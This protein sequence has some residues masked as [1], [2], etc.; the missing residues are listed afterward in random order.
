VRPDGSGLRQLTSGENQDVGPSW[1]RSRGTIA[2]Q[3]L[4]ES[5]S[6]MTRSVWL[7]RA[8]GSHP[9]RLS[10]AGPSLASGSSALAY[11]PDG[12]LLAG[13]CQFGEGSLYGVTILDLSTRRS[14]IV[15]RIQCEGGVTSL[16]WS[17]DGT[18]LAVCVEY[19]GGAGLFRVDPVHG[20]RIP[21]HLRYAA[22]SVSWRPDGD[23]LLCRVWRS[24]L[25]GYPTW[26]MLFKPDGT[27]VK[28]LAKAQEDPTCSPDGRHYAFA[29]LAADGPTG[30]Y[31]AD[32]DGTHA[33]KVC[34]GD[35]VWGIAWR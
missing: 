13:G 14:R 19:G 11:S 23:R 7:V 24:D 15:A 1:S 29:A 27:R 18:Q 10:Y 21:T 5:A 20:G 3:R 16:S 28:V 9:R 12:R 31:V 2:F 33:R 4:R 25:P 32:A 26:T 34:G 35:S 17:P 6:D 22:S 8:D 30:L